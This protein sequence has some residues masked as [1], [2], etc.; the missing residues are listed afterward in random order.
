MYNY[1]DSSWNNIYQWPLWVRPDSLLKDRID[2]KQVV[3]HTKVRNIFYKNGIAFTD[4][5]ETQNQYLSIDD[6]KFNVKN[7]KK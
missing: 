6:T 1:A 7:F 3:W 2:W 4:V 5:L